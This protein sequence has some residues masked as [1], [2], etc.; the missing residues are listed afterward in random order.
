[1]DQAIVQAMIDAA[2]QAAE[3]N[4][5]AQMAAT[6]QANAQLRQDLQAAQNQ[7][8]GLIAQPAVAQPQ[9]MAPPQ[10]PPPVPVQFALTPATAGAAN[11]IID[12]TTTTGA[13]LYK[14]AIEE[15]TVKFDLDRQ[16]LH[17]FL[18]SLRSR[19]IEQGWF[20]TLLTIQVGA[21]QLNLLDNYGTITKEQVN[22]HA[23]GIIFRETRAA[24]DSS[25]L[26]HCLETSLTTEARATLYAE[27]AT[28]TYRRGDHPALMLG[29][30]DPEERRRDGLMFLWAIINLTTAKTTA[31]ITVLLKQL[32]N[33]PAVMTECNSD[34]ST[35]NTKVYKLINMY[36]ANKQQEFDDTILLDNL[37][38]AYR[39][40]KDQHFTSYID[41]RW[42][43]HEDGIRVLTP[44]ELMEFALKQFQ[45]TQDHGT[46]GA[47]TKNQKSI[48]NLTSRLGKI[49]KADKKK[50]DEKDDSKKKGEKKTFVS[51]KE[52]REQRYKAAPKWMKKAPADGTTKKTVDG[53]EYLWCVYHKLWGKHTPDMCQVNP[54]NKKPGNEKDDDKK[55]PGEPK[56]KDPGNKPKPK[57]SFQDAK[58]AAAVEY[59][60][61]DDY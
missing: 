54:K 50:S 40:A 6:N 56:P 24:Q 10:Q 43:D 46:W 30:G 4:M 58:S 23:L 29:A 38:M 16:N 17:D 2:V 39:M 15:L 48:M 20:D 19:A 34:I 33:L 8:A 28:Y 12:Y 11:A 61:E 31:T 1:M 42:S 9:V 25:N 53:V 22:Q 36:R 18:E 51:A 47:D 49:E 3:A 7:I 14:A 52:Y 32:N 57:V 35:F 60:I 21:Q 45:T 5:A 26:F 41:R 13:K 59:D 27:S 55:S 37:Q 44:Q